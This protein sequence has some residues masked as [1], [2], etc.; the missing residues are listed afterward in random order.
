M[1][2]LSPD[3]P[4]HGL[5][6]Q[7]SELGLRTFG[8]APLRTRGQEAIVP[9][10][11]DRSRPPEGGRDAHRGTA[12]DDLHRADRRAPSGGRTGV[13]PG[14]ASADPNARSGARAMSPPRNELER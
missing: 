10:M 9:H 13:A 2:P 11:G 6:G 8:E 3:D 14:G 7:Q 4:T 1:R 5:V 12:A